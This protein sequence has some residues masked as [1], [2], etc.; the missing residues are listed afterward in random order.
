MNRTPMTGIDV[1]LSDLDG[2]VYRGSEPV[3][4]A[5]L[6]L[7][8][9]AES[10]RVG[11]VTNSAARA[12]GT[13]ATHLGSLGIETSDDCIVTSAHAMAWLLPSWVPHGSTVLVVGSDSLRSEVEAAGYELTRMARDE[14][15][16]V[17]QGFAEDFTWAQLSQAALALRSDPGVA[18]FATN[19]DSTVPSPDGLLL[20]NGAL[21][22]AVAAAVGRAPI[23]AGKPETPIYRAALE[24]F[25][26]TR[27]L[28]VGDRLDTDVLGGRR[29]GLASALVL[30][31]AHGVDDLLAAAPEM[32]PD[33]ILEDLRGLTESY[34]EPE[35]SD[36]GLSCRA[37]GATVE[38]VDGAPRVGRAGSDI[39]ATRASC[40]LMWHHRDRELA[41]QLS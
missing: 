10:A 12:V 26:A 5:A 28:F 6:G 20:E 37:G 30:T 40:T 32:R 23:V 35:L 39:E 41:G 3:Q 29:A 17:V 9:C 13:I 4:F 15:A 1:L 31:G 25:D 16:A 34:D 14:P 36:D 38:L 11:F 33:Y 27:A 21:V 24:R 18:W 22:A 8:R 2:V 19:L 7:S